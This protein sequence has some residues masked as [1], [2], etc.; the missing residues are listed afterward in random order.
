[1]SSERN[2]GGAPLDPRRV[3][4]DPGEVGELVPVGEPAPL[5]PAGPVDQRRTAKP[6]GPGRPPAEGERNAARGY[7][8]QYLVAAGLVYDALLDGRLEWLALA[9]PEAGRVDDLQVAT[10][11]RLDAYQVKWHAFPGPLTLGQLTRAD[12]G[13][14]G[15]AGLVRHLADGWTSLETRHPGREVHVHL[16]TNAFPSTGEAVP[17]SGTRKGEAKHFAAFVALGW[18]PAPGGVPSV[19]DAWGP[20]LERLREASGLPD[21]AFARFRARFHL[22][23]GHHVPADDEPGGGAAPRVR[24]VRAVA[25]H[26]WHVVGREHR[27]VRLDRDELLRRL[28]WRGRFEFRARHEFPVDEAV[29]QPIEATVDELDACVDRHASGYAA[30][31]GTPGSGK[32]TTLTR[33]LRYRSGVRVVR[34]YCFVPDDDRPSRGEALDFL[35][36]LVLALWREGVRPGRRAIGVTLDELREMLHAQ[37]GELHAR[38]RERGERTMVL[39]D[40]LDHIE[41]EQSPQRSLVAELP[42]PGAVPE[43]VLIVLGSQRLDLGSL[44]PRIGH[45]LGQAGRTIRMRP[46]GRRAVRAAVSSVVRVPMGE[47][48]LRRVEEL[49]AGHPLAL[50][51]LLNRLRDAAAPGDVERALDGIPAYSGHIEEHYAVYWRGVAGAREVRELLALLA[52]LRGPLDLRLAAGWAGE[53]TVEELVATAVHYFDREGPSTLRFFH[54]SFRQF[55]LDRTG[56]GPFADEHDE[57]RHRGYHRRLA[58]LAA[59]SRTAAFRWDELYHRYQAREHDAVRRVATQAFFREQFL[60]LRSSAQVR[61]DVAL[62]MRAA[63]AGRDP[64]AV[65]RLVLVDEELSERAAALAEVDVPGLLLDLGDAEA[66]VAAVLNEREL[67][68]GEGAALRFAVRLAERGNAAAAL[69]VFEAAEPL[70]VLN[71]AAGV[72]LRGYGSDASLLAWTGAAP[73]FRPMAVILEQIDRLR[74]ASTEAPEVEGVDVARERLRGDLLAELANGL[75]N[76]GDLDQII[77]LREL[78]SGW[79]EGD[80]ALVRLDVSACARHRHAEW[81]DAAVNRLLARNRA[82][83]LPV[84]IRLIVAEAVLARTADLRT[85]EELIADIQQPELIDR[86]GGASFAPGLGDFGDRIRLNRLLSALGRPVR[87]EVAV[88]T[89]PDERLAG[90]V[91]FERMLVAV[92]NLWG[93]AWR[94]DALNPD[95]VLR[96]LRPAVG[97]YNR[98]RDWTNWFYYKQL[99]EHYFEFLVNAAAAHGRGALLRLT[100]EFDRQWEA[101]ATR[102]FWRTGLRRSVALSLHRAGGDAGRLVG[103]LDRLDAELDVWEDLHERARA[104]VDQIRAWLAAGRPERARALLPRL[105]ATS[106]GVY[107]DKDDQL[108][109]WA[110]WFARLA[111]VEPRAAEA[112]VADLAGGFAVAAAAGRGSNPA[113]AVATFLA[114]AAPLRPEVGASLR[115][116]FLDQR[117]LGFVAA[118]EALCLASL[119]D[120]REDVRPA[121][122]TVRRL[123][124]PFQRNANKKVARALVARLA[125]IEDRELA[126]FCFREL[127]A[128]VE[129][130]LPPADRP[131][132]WRSLADCRDAPR[133]WL[134]LLRRKL[135][136]A[137]P[138][139]PRHT[140]GSVEL[141]SGE[142]IQEAD[143]AARVRTPLDLAKLLDEVAEDRFHGWDRLIGPMLT[144]MDRPTA[145]SLLAS[146]ERAGVNVRTRMLVIDRLSGL[147]ATDQ[148]EALAVEALRESG[149]NG[150]LTWYDGGSRLK[151]FQALTRIGD[152]YAE[153]ALLQFADDYLGEARNPR[154]IV[155]SLQDLVDVFWREPPL[156]RLWEE[157]R[158]HVLQL[159][160]FAGAPRPPP[161]PAEGEGPATLSQALTD[162]LFEAYELPLPEF[163]D[164][165]GRAIVWLASRSDDP[166]AVA[167]RVSRLLDGAGEAQLLGLAL[168]EGL[169]EHRPETLARLLAQVREASRSPDIGARASAR[170]ILETA[171]AAPLPVPPGRGR[172]PASYLLEFPDYPTDR[173]QPS[174]AWLA[175]G[176]ALPDTS[177]P[178]ELVGSATDQLEFLHEVTG[179]PLRN[180]VERT[181]ALMRK[182]EPPATWDA[183]AERSLAK[184]CRALGPEI[185]YRR[186]RA[187][188]ARLALAHVIAEL[189]DAGAVDAGALDHLLAAVVVRD[190]RLASTNPV[191]G[192]SPIPLT[193]T[194]EARS[195]AERWLDAAVEEGDALPSGDGWTVLGFASTADQP[196][197]DRPEEMRVGGLCSPLVDAALLGDRPDLIIPGDWCWR[198]SAY[199]GLPALHD[200]LGLSLVIRGVPRHAL[201]GRAEWLALNPLVAARLGWRPAHDGLFRWVDAAGRTMVESVWWRSGRLGRSPYEDEVRAEGWTVRASDPAVPALAAAAQGAKWVQGTTKSIRSDTKKGSKEKLSVRV[202]RSAW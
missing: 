53:A 23:F 155:R 117:A 132:W 90:S 91:L 70:G 141:R 64:L 30:L 26:L 126:D 130:D 29:Y 84:W 11:G 122:A 125:A 81:V 43:G 9:D 174:S 124:L 202:G 199:P 19:P 163:R 112:A 79:P 194:R 110:G 39:V 165:A 3:A 27:V 129:T 6:A 75:V 138:E 33:T 92:A 100:D 160:D 167:D 179:V 172:L 24:D 98:G 86:P 159:V 80:A 158:D 60:A 97:L 16:V 28:G 68:V 144:S 4:P 134:R 149:A 183:A 127:L 193:L 95:Q 59:G 184:R 177:D 8:A 143:L 58:E 65:V 107:H 85:V 89:A 32:S 200:A 88:P 31:I 111:K 48:Q 57:D 154:E 187:L 189:H 145:T 56:R 52:R 96:V 133:A 131:A 69:R 113:G 73:L 121:F 63:R 135:A 181:V 182:L 25:D 87:P 82:G 198:A 196:V 171:G 197:W 108:G 67:R 153:Q 104:H 38:W 77:E 192:T 162:V 74:V 15:G 78:V 18:R 115:R 37:L 151:A 61:D 195:S 5:S 49:T 14:P 54:N 186:P 36:D 45:Q 62:A 166:T 40:G 120:P 35:H 101:E 161:A 147:G 94:G 83:R 17:T 176:A 50:N 185:A 102:H 128:A 72:E 76:R 156:A 168:A 51:Y 1:M 142:V 71:R 180:L 140:P 2:P 42:Q 44:N 157:V 34:Y 109:C 10:P 137:E 136:A 191:P 105:L 190:G 148:A 119:R 201:V 175:P 170:R 47:G 21:E 123:C 93:D 41:R 13:D 99:D 150:W 46:L 139:E 22:D 118:A 7:S 114:A 116:W 103:C 152:Q 20:T 12:S 173:R 66:A 169:A 178:I 188:A 106:F 164:D 55:V 146:L